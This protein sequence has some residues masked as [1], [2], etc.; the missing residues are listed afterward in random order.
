MG[1]LLCC[2]EDSEGG[3]AALRAAHRLASALGLELV[4]LHVAPHTAAPG[5]GA[6][7]AAHAR[8]RDEE[9]RDAEALLERL[10]AS[11]PPA[12]SARRVVRVG[13]AASAILQEAAA[14][15]A[16]LIVIGSRGRAGVRAALLGS[17]STAVA[18][19][20][21]CPCVIVPPGAARSFLAG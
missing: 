12:E 9:R 10:A 2:V 21:P 13:S 4:L 19:N 6:A 17:V 3:R 16:E 15:G 18:A 14:T 20:A 8:L 5:V 11:E 7:P 1:P